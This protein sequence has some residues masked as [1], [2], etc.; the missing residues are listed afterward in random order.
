MY[1]DPA[2]ADLASSLRPP[3]PATAP[4]AA[5]LAPAQ[6]HFHLQVA[7]LD[8]DLDFD[9]SS[10]IETLKSWPRLGVHTTVNTVRNSL[11]KSF[12]RYNVRT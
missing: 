12:A 6:P 7:V 5:R 10:Q 11:A 3:A 1:S 9:Q 2:A 4:G 8:L